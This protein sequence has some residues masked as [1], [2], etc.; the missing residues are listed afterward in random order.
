MGF[1]ISEIQVMLHL[2]KNYHSTPPRLS[3]VL[4]KNAHLL[5]TEYS[6]K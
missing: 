4:N 6:S 3:L 2:L 5:R 1:K